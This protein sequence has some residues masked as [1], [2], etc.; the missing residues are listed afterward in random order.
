MKW[1]YNLEPWR[2]AA[3]FWTVTPALIL[4]FGWL[5]WS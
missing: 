2:G 3:W 1:L 4:L 5:G